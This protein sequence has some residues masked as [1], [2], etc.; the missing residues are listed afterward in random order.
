MSV[1]ARIHR[2]LLRLY[3][4][5]FRE[6]FGGE[7]TAAFL[8]TLASRATAGAR[9]AFVARAFVDAVSS[10]AG[11]RADERRS[12]LPQHR[13]APVI[14]ARLQALRWDAR[15]ALRA[16]RRKPGFV[17]AVVVTLALGIGAN[18]AVFSL[19]D[20]VLLHPI[21][22]DRPEQLVAVHVARSELLR[23]EPV[24]YPLF[25][26]IETRARGRA[27][28]AGFKQMSVGV[29]HDGRSEQLESALVS[30]D[31]FEM[32]GVR[33]QRGRLIQPDDDRTIGAHFVVV[34]SDALWARWFNRSV[35]ALG[36]V[37]HAGENAYT[38][39]GIAPRDFQGTRLSERPLLWFPIT[40]ATSVGVGGLFSRRRPND[41]YTTNAFGWVDVIARVNDPRAAASVESDLNGILSDYARDGQLTVGERGTLR[42]ISLMPLTRA[43]T[44]RGRDDVVRFVSIL[45]GVVAFTLL[46]ACVNVANLLLA[47]SA[48]RRKELSLRAALGASRG[49]LARQLLFESMI[50]AMLGAAAGIGVGL[51]TMRVLSAFTLPGQISLDAVGLGLDGRVL[52]FT[53]A[54]AIASAII[55]GLVPAL[56][57]SRE[58]PI[59][60]LRVHGRAGARGP[61]NIFLAIQVALSL[62]LLVAAS[63]FA[64]S[65]Q[66]GLRS[67]LG[68]DPRPLALVSVDV[69]RH[70]YT[71]QR[72]D[73]YYAAAIARARALPGVSA[74][75]VADHVPLGPFV[76]LPFSLAGAPP[77]SAVDAGLNSIT[78]DYFDVVGTRLLE[79]R[80]F[81]AGD[82]R[83]VPNVAIVNESAARL[84]MP[85]QS[86]VGRELRLMASIPVHVVGVVRDTKYESVRDARVP[87][88]FM[89]ITQQPTLTPAKIVVRSV[90]PR[91][92][93]AEL[94]RQIA[95]IDPDVPVLDARLVTDQLDVALM[96]QRF[97][98]TLLGLFAF[99]ALGVT[100]VGVYGVASYGVNR[101][102]GEIGIRIAL[103][104]RRSDIVRTVLGR[105]GNAVV[106]G[107]IAGSLGAAVA[108]RGLQRF[109]FAVAPRDPVSFIAAV[110]V[111]A[112]AAV[113]ACWLPARR[114]MAVDPMTV[115]RD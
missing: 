109:L 77:T 19:I 76:R 51:A 64:R 5:S 32:L 110:V 11:A 2:L 43:A 60:M 85:G 36:S 44:L 92:S 24:Q 39:V 48:E 40:M 106:V 4:R 3:P 57:S 61:R 98:A 55:F 75:A 94:R 16:L 111:T 95:A 52:A 69:M 37:I 10:A 114:A 18:T 102:L 107:V 17:V 27:R 8:E 105:S 42:S 72:S 22:V 23:Y 54:A 96:P 70:G 15:T 115:I 58:Q 62:V 29:K 65:L 31:Y 47:R 108:S 90:E 112:V 101:R 89:P 91:Q 99:I 97:G 79:G 63:L 84:L 104:A 83:S 67:D 28:I 49:R 12:R 45:L 25:R 56:T 74:V 33:A 20:A 30:G 113:L 46:V 81:T 7:M 13:H 38:I 35:R 50:L 78:P 87:M 14:G 59:G 68:F 71:R 6:R 86:V 80:V 41:V 26:T 93:L 53:S 9:A 34:L 103:G 66:A 21:H 82:D 1:M 73:A 88:V 100:I